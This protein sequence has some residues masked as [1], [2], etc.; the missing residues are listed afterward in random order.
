MPISLGAR[1]APTQYSA[2]AMQCPSM[3]RVT[4]RRA[5][6]LGDDEFDERISPPGGEVQGRHEAR[7]EVDRAGGADADPEERRIGGSGGSAATM[8]LAHRLVELAEDAP[9]RSGD[10]DGALDERAAGVDE[11]GLDLGAAEVD[12]EH[13]RQ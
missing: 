6:D 7:A 3:R 2:S 13:E 10:A 12:G 9:R 4:V 5:H 1:A 8:T 11:R